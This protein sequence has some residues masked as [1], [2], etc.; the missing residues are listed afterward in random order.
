MG[1]IST[2]GENLPAVAMGMQGLVA[3]IIMGAGSLSAFNTALMTMSGMILGVV[4]NVNNLK[5][6]FSNFV[7]TPPNIG[8]FI[9]AFAAIT[10]SARQLIPSLTAVG[11][12][13]GAGLASGL[14][15]GAARARAMVSS[16]VASMIAALKPLPSRFAAVARQA[17]SHERI[18]RSN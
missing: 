2:A 15:A 6:A 4:T 13:A 11:R 14:S 18:C 8:P 16:V 3:A 17:G 10:A 7:I 5:T 1:E 12:Q 9:A